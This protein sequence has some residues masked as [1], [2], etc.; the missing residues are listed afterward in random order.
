MWWKISKVESY[1]IYTK[2]VTSAAFPNFSLITS[3]TVRCTENVYRA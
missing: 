3:K 1:N 2:S